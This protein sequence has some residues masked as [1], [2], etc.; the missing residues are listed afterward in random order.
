MFNNYLYFDNSCEVPDR[1]LLYQADHHRTLN[2]LYIYHD[3]S[4]TSS[5]MSLFVICE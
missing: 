1:T 5:F 2:A 3:G 4:Y